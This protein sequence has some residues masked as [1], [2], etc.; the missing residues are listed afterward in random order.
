MTIT[1]V[2]FY[3]R[4]FCEWEF[5]LNVYLMK[6]PIILKP[7]YTDRCIESSA[8]LYYANAMSTVVGFDH[9]P[10]HTEAKIYQVPYFIIVL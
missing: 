4:S 9:K 3:N 2:L 8:E 5:T 6:F 1:S 7:K 10:G